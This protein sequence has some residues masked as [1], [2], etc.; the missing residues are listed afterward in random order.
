METLEKN[1]PITLWDCIYCGKHL[2]DAGLCERAFAP[3]SV[4]KELILCGMCPK[5]LEERL[6]AEYSSIL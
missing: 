2:N 6:P 3:N 4:L 1:I 5:C